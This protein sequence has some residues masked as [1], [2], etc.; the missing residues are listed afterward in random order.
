MTYDG[1]IEEL[2]NYFP[3]LWEKYKDEG[4]YIEG[5][6]HLCYE[7]VFVPFIRQTCLDAEEDKMRLIC[8]FME[9]MAISEDGMVSEV[10]AVSVLESLLGEQK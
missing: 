10:L 9:Q 1:L 2:L 4:D 8:D 7:I 3:L 5:L 6:S